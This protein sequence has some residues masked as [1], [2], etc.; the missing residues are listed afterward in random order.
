MVTRLAIAFG[1]VL[2]GL[3]P[4]S[5]RLGAQNTADPIAEFKRLAAELSAARLERRQR[6]AR[7]SRRNPSSF[8]TPLRL[9]C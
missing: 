7:R 5:T 4:V 2:L 6:K 1:I 3:T 9:R 8:W